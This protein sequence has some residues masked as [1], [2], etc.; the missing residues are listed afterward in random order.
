MKI[1]APEDETKKWL[2]FGYKILRENDRKKVLDKTARKCYNVG[3]GGGTPHPGSG[4]GSLRR[5]LQ[6]GNKN[7]F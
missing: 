6:N 7:I 5:R 4:E 3:T 2:Q 1:Q